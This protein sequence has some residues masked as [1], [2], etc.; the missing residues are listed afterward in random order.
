M[1]NL[2]ITSVDCEER[3]YKQKGVKQ[4]IVIHE[5]YIRCF[6]QFE[7][8]VLDED[9]GMHVDKKYDYDQIIPK[10]SIGAIEMCYSHKRDIYEVVIVT[11]MKDDACYLF[12]TKAEAKAIYDELVEWFVKPQPLP[13]LNCP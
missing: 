6:A 1:K 10:S 5:N 12:E 11:L 7:A 3:T 9:L 8:S 13:G 2:S 4:H